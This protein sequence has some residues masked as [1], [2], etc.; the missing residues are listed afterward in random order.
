LSLWKSHLLIRWLRS[1]P[2]YSPYQT[3]F[4]AYLAH[5]DRNLITMNS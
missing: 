2:K 4:P 5:F 3:V 1:Q